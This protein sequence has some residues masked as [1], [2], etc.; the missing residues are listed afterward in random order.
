MADNAQDIT[1]VLR[2]ATLLVR[3]IN[4]SR[5]FYEGVFGLSVYAACDGA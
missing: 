5:V 2:R 3:D 4:R 1:S